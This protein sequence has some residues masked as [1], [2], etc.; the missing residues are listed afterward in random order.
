MIFSYSLKGKFGQLCATAFFC[1]AL[2]STKTQ[3]DVATWDGDKDDHAKD[4]KNWVG[5]S[6]PA[7]NFTTILRFGTHSNGEYAVK[8]DNGRTYNLLG[9]EFISTT[10]AYT[11]RQNQLNFISQ[12][13]ISN[14]SGKT[15][16]IENNLNLLGDFSFFASNDISIKGSINGSGSVVN[17][18]GQGT[19]TLTGYNGYNGG[20]NVYD[21]T[22]AIGGSYRMNSTGNMTL[23]NGSQLNAGSFTNQVNALNLIDGDIVGSG[24]IRASSFDLRNGD[25]FANL[26]GSGP[27]NKN[28]TGTVT[29]Y[30]TNNQVTNDTFINEGILRMGADNIL[31]NYTNLLIDGGTLDLDTF[32]DTV[33]TATLSSG[34]I[35]SDTGILTANNF[36]G[37][38]VESGLVDAVLAGTRLTKSSTG[39]VTLK[40]SNLFTAG[41]FI[42][43]GTLVLDTDNALYATGDVEINNGARLQLN[44][45][46]N[47]IGELRLNSGEITG[48]GSLSADS[49]EVRSGTVEIALTGSGGL[50]KSTTG[51]VQLSGNNSYTGGTFLS[52]GTLEAL[53]DNVLSDNGD[54][55]IGGSSN[56]SQIYGGGTYALGAFSE[57]IQNLTI[58]SGSLTG[59]GTLTADSFNLVLGSIDANLS[60]SGALTKNGP[61][62]TTFTLSGDHSYTGGTNINSGTLALGA[63]STFSH[64]GTFLVD[65]GRFSVNNY[66]ASV[67]NLALDSGTI[68]GSGTISATSYAVEAGTILANLAGASA[69]LTKSGSGTVTLSGSNTYGGG[70]KISM[71]II[72]IG[73]NNV[74]ATDSTVEVASGA[75]YQLNNYSQQLGALTGSGA[76]TLGNSG[77]LTL[78]NSTAQSFSGSVSGG[79]GT[80]INKQGNETYTIDGNFSG[81][82]G[83]LNIA[84]GTLV[85]DATNSQNTV[86]NVVASGRLNAR[87]LIDAL[88]VSGGGAFSAAGDGGGSGPTTGQLSANSANFG[89]NGIYTFHVN[90]FAGSPGA[91]SGWDHV[92]INGPLT[93]TTGSPFTIALASLTS[94]NIS[95]DATNF[96]PSQ[97]YRLDLITANSGISIGA[98]FALNTSQFTNAFNGNFSLELTNSNKTLALT[99]SPVI[100]EPAAYS[101]ILASVAGC[102][103]A[104]RRRKR[105]A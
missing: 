102:A 22:L 74:F 4:W 38:T 20:T 23:Y 86:V 41:T 65:G 2:L 35:I 6:A 40:K 5:D 82:N 105:P 69:K 19:L 85:M 55:T 83:S 98:A 60:G 66:T 61:G 8:F 49:F 54:L 57:T 45:I 36:N 93:V 92:Q 100:P 88:N 37:F 18:Q 56:A 50:Y 99:Y 104:L 33:A 62:Y 84:S 11:L 24:T 64:T 43:A 53:A 10:N 12:G 3:A 28:G 75:T 13:Y 16:V 47:T 9:I 44:N 1:C 7:Y 15:A 76:L 71:G 94:A 17:K 52:S 29:L 67:G 91:S 101:F 30:G 58:N 26:S 68:T 25:V 72:A 48:S 89:A 97:Y 27:L 79:N 21:G 42:D 81:Y 14:N 77:S 32:N 46:D 80:S 70:T 90:N 103:I 34:S 31:L 59:T 87:G 78:N 39:T 63:D 73:A 95:G 51:T 96:D